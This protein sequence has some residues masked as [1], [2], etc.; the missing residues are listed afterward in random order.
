M[1]YNT[2]NVFFSVCVPLGKF[3]II[4]FTIDNIF[5]VFQCVFVNL[6]QKIKTS[7]RIHLKLNIL[8]KNAFTFTL[9]GGRT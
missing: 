4:S 6:R 9:I 8:K 5:D 7:Q 1:G 3:L 2:H